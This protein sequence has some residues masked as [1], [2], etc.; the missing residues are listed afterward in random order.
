MSTFQVQNAHKPIKKQNKQINNPKT[1]EK[2][3]FL[4]NVSH[5]YQARNVKKMKEIR[6]HRGEKD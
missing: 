5:P 2:I 3:Y 6:T 4:S 1:A